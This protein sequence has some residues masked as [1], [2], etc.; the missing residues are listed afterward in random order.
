MQSY[1]SK[2]KIVRV[3]LK[4]QASPHILDFFN[5]TKSDSM[6]V[7]IEIDLEKMDIKEAVFQIFEKL[8]VHDI[9]ITNIPIEEVIKKIY[10][11]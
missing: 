4:N 7:E 8:P 9:D 6:S 2:K 5:V 3:K 10:A 1:Y 11:Q